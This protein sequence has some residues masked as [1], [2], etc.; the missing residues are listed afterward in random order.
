MLSLLGVIVFPL[1]LL[2]PYVVL[3]HFIVE[4]LPGFNGKLP[5]KL[6]T[7]Q[8]FY[9]GVGEEEKVQ[10]YYYFVESE[11]DPENDPLMLWLTGGPG[12]SG[13]S[14]FVYE[15]GPLMFDYANSSGD[16][17][18]LEL[19]SNS[20]TKVANIIFIDQPAG[21]GYSYARTSEAYNCND[22]LAVTLTYE[23]LRKWLMDHPEY[24][25]N[26]LYVGGDSYSGIFVALLTRRIYNG[27]E[28]GEKPRVNIKGYIQGNALTDHYIDFNGRVIYAHRM[29][30]ISDKIYQSTKANCNGNYAEVD[31][32]NVACLNDL[33]R[34]D[35]CL[36]NIRRAHILEPWCDLPFLTS[37]LQENP[38]N[39]PSLF[40]IEGPWCR[41]KN[42][43]YSYVWANDKAV[44]KALKVREVKYSQNDYELTYATVKGGGHTAPEYKPEQCLAMV[45]RWFS[46]FPL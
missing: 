44:Q 15:I 34:V 36:K 32:N 31:P 42:Y 35:R 30:L 29:G 2:L 26:P 12:C 11:R 24:L 18:K 5:F 17:P 3:S 27:I 37:I 19:N 45:D 20:W 8:V 16:F 41:E 21:S 9:V 13:L 22:T 4:T 33:Q 23:F 38:T 40:P 14:S 39:A 1:L 6:E 7:G 10:L 25:K 46:G 28:V 43:I